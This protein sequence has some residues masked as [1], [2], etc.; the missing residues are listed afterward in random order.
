MY[1][2]VCIAHH[3]TDNTGDF[4]YLRGAGGINDSDFL[5]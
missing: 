3:T 1:V 2:Y 5:F 4:Y